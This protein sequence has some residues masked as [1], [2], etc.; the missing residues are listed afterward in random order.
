VVGDFDPDAMTERIEAQFGSM[1]A[2]TGAGLAPPTPAGRPDGR[3]IIETSKPMAAV[4]MGFGPVPRRDHPDFIPME[5]L[6]KVVSNF[7]SGWLQRALRGEGQG[8]VYAAWGYQRTGVVPGYWTIAFN[9]APAQAERAIDESLRLVQRLRAE[10]VDDATLQRARSATLVSEM[11]G[12]QSYGQQAQRLALD[13]LY[14]LGYEHADR[15]ADAVRDVTAADVRAM[16]EKYLSDQPLILIM[17]D[18]PIDASGGEA[19][20]EEPEESTSAPAAGAAD[21]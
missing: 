5:V 1:P 10:P 6:T 8:L 15:F 4:Q 11:L 13:E 3:K 14:G 7:P 21:G 17:S 20:E 9:T 16:A 12:R 19:G 2:S 18:E